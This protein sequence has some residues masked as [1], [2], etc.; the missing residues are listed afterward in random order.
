MDIMKTVAVAVVAAIVMFTV[1]RSLKKKKYGSLVGFLEQGNFKAFYQ[2]LDKTSSKILFSKLTLMDLR[3][4]AAMLEQRSKEAGKI[5]DEIGKMP[6]TPR[7]KENFYMKAF[8]YYVGLEDKKMSKKYLDLINGLSNE[9]MKFEA[10]RVYNIFILKTDKD[11]K[12]LLEELESMEDNEKGVN[13]YLISV[14][15]KNLKDTKNQKKY[16]ELSRTHFAA[17]DEMTAQKLQE[18][19]GR[20]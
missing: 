5:L 18:Q 13:E 7:E 16:E 4:N 6:L 10:N 14:I 8:N 20:K 9:R 1:I 15:Y 17:V 19:G 2:E 12:D 3:L 11:L